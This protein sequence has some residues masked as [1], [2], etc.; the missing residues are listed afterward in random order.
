MYIAYILFIHY[1]LDITHRWLIILEN[2]LIK[3]YTFYIEENNQHKKTRQPRPSGYQIL[4][5]TYLLTV[6]CPPEKLMHPSQNQD[7]CCLAWEISAG[8]SS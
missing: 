6:S 7:L 2:R 1:L 3:H 5:N 4:L 8:T